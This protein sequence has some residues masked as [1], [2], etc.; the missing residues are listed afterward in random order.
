VQILQ[1]A[2]GAPIS[3]VKI[4]D[5]PTLRHRGIHVDLKGYQ[6]RFDSLLQ[7]LR[8]LSRF[9][10]NAILLEVEDKFAYG[11]A[12]EVGALSRCPWI[13]GGFRIIVQGWSALGTMESVHARCILKT[14]PTA[15]DGSALPK[16]AWPASGPGSASG[17]IM[18]NGLALQLLRG[19][20][21]EGEPLRVV[22]AEGVPDFL[23]WSCCQPD[24]VIFG[25]TAGSWKKSTPH[26][27][28]MD[29]GW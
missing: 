9:R 23:T 22:I 26:A 13:R 15:P 8:L 14:P 1:L 17:L 10:I 3:A 27:C 29:P 11:C 24:L 6:P 2:D 7:M 4:R 21:T 20:W 19:Q 5:W 28:P 18:A 12:A 25:V 16:G